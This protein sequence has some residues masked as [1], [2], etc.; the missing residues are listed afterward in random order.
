MLHVRKSLNGSLNVWP[1][2]GIKKHLT[3]DIFVDILDDAGEGGHVL[4]C[5]GHAQVVA[6]E[7]VSGLQHGG[8]D[9]VQYA[10]C[11]TQELEQE[12]SLY[13]NRKT[14]LMQCDARK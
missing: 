8:G 3:F 11:Q 14:S 6:N 7:I 2:L 4:L 13:V 12:M 10:W 1:E 5:E 9:K